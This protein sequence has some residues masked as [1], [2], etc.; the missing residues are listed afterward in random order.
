MPA[1]FDSFEESQD[2][3]D[4]SVCLRPNNRELSFW[5]KSLLHPAVTKG[6]KCGVNET[7]PFSVHSIKSAS[8]VKYGPEVECTSFEEPGETGTFT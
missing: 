1:S 5:P 7:I 4:S 8:F 2:R 3:A 6:D